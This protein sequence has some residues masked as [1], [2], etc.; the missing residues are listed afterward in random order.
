[1]K[2]LVMSVLINAA[3]LSV[4][5][6][7]VSGIRYT[8]TLPGLL[9]VALVFGFVNTVIRPI[10]MFF[11]LPALIVTLGLFTLVINAFMLKVTGWLASGWGFQVD[12]FGA[13]FKGAL[14]I[15]VVSWVL[16]L[17]APDPAKSSDD[18]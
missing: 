1:M 7:Y 10:L 4:A 12:G 5:A 15:S 9:V 2:R 17:F 3:A 14:L 8:G 18:D 13:A 16:G 6:Y 11:S